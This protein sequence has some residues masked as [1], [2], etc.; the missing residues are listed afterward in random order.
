VV[1]R[2]GDLVICIY[3]PF[4]RILLA[5]CLLRDDMAEVPFAC[6]ETETLGRQMALP[7]REGVRLD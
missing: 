5:E 1:R 7:W 4:A 2:G 3:T 6:C